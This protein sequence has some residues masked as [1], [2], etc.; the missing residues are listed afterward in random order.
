MWHARCFSELW[1]VLDALEE[2]FEGLWAGPPTTTTTTPTA[3][4]QVPQGLHTNPALGHTTVTGVTHSDPIFATVFV[5]LRL[6]LF[7]G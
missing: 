3:A 7:V 2:G 6:A 5:L 4:N 1:R